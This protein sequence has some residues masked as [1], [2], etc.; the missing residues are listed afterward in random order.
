MIVGV[1]D[2]Y[3]QA[4]YEK[5]RL[6]DQDGSIARLTTNYVISEHVINS[7]PSSLPTPDIFG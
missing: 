4:H 7:I 3:E 1:Y 2:S 6:I 5:Q